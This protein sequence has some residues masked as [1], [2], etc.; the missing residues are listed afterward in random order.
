MSTRYHVHVYWSSPA[1]REQAMRFRGAI[2]ARFPHAQLG[3]VHDAPVAF[4]PLP[5]FQVSLDLLDVGALF[6]W[7]PHHR[8][9]LSLLVHP[10]T[11][12]AAEEHQSLATWVGPPVVMDVQR[13]RLAPSAALPTRPAISGTLLRIDASARH[14]GS[15]SREL[16]DRLVSH[17]GKQAPNRPVVRRD[18][19]DGVPL[20]NPSMLEAFGVP[21]GDRSPAQQ[22]AA[23]ASETLMAELRASEHIVLALPIYNFGVPA[24]FKAW[25]DLVSRARETFAYTSDGPRGLL[26]DRPVTI[27]LTSGGTRM[28]SELDFVTPWLRHVLGFIGLHDLR[29]VFADGL[30]KDPSRLPLAHAQIDQLAPA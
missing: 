10:L 21:A 29:F 11:G 17:L 19:T 15:I 16:A 24:T 7:L 28:G 23:L 13:L 14:Q 25:I 18:L 27:V 2:S 5:M 26:A 6:A 30:M 12:D 9:S 8:G 1:I 22:H 3:D 4:H 20:L